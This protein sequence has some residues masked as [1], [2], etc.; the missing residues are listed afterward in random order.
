MGNR[1]YPWGYKWAR[2]DSNLRPWDYESP[3]L[4][5]ELH[6]RPCVQFRA[7]CRPSSGGPV[8]GAERVWFGTIMG[9]TPGSELEQES[10]RV[11][12]V[13]LTVADLE[14]SVD[15]YRGAIGLNQLSR[16]GSTARMGVGQTTLVELTE[17][18][19]A[20]PSV[21]RTGLFHLALRVPERADLARWVLAASQAGVRIEGGRRPLGE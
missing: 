15:F 8:A 4:T 18:P 2:E 3:A 12:A 11:G 13:G 9:M 16:S 21:G 10:I 17:E 5:A 20:A 1:S 19:G 6:A 14:R 7:V